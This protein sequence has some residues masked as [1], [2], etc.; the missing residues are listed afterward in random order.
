MSVT[1]GYFKTNKLK[2]LRIS[3]LNKEYK[4]AF[5]STE[6]SLQLKDRVFE[7]VDPL[8]FDNEIDRQKAIVEYV[9]K[10]FPVIPVEDLMAT[11]SDELGGLMLAAQAMVEGFYLKFQEDYIDIAAKMTVEEAEEEV[12]KK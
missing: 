7:L 12:K 1:T 8:L 5:I 2:P 9:N 3:S 4:I 10:V 6:L 11:P